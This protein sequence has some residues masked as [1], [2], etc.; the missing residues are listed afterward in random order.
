MIPHYKRI[1]IQSIDYFNFEDYRESVTRKR[2]F[3]EKYGLR[4]TSH[5]RKLI[6]FQVVDQ[7]KF[8]LFAINHG[9]LIYAKP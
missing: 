2:H 3:L 7:K 9:D 8:M 1:K 5:I 6:Y 4:L